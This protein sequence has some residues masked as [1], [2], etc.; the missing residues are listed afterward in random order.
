MPSL[1]V[2][3]ALHGVED[4]VHERFQGDR[5]LVRHEEDPIPDAD[6]EA[7]FREP[8]DPHALPR[9]RT[10]EGGRPERG[11]T[12]TTIIIIATTSIIVVVIIIISL[13]VA[14]PRPKVRPKLR[15]KVRPKVCPKVRPKVRP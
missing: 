12:T 10:E 4:S 15:P 5:A 13:P 7:I 11:S 3:A 8:V 14:C 2:V 9:D 1:V 6:Q